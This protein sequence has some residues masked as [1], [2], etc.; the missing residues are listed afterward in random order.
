MSSNQTSDEQTFD[1]EMATS[2]DVRSGYLTGPGIYQMPV[3]YNVVDGIALFSG[4]ID[5]GPVEEVEAEAARIRATHQAR[6]AD[7]AHGEEDAGTEAG[8]DMVLLGVGLPRDSSFLW[9]NG[10]VAYAIASN[11]SNPS[12]ITDAIRHL[13]QRSP[14]RFTERTAAN[15]AQHPN[16]IEFIQHAS[17]NSSPIGMRGGR[18]RIR[19]TAGA[20]LGT[21]VHEIMHSLG[22]FHEQSRS[23]RDSF[24][25]IRWQNIDPTKTGNFQKVPGSVDYYDYDYGSLMHYP[26][27]A[28]SVNGQDTIVPRRSGVS[29]GQRSAMSWGDRQTVAKLYERF[30]TK[31]YSGVW[32]AHSGRYGLWAN[33]SWQSFQ[34]KWQEWSG[35]GLR[36]IDIHT[37]RVG[38]TT[39]YTGVFRAGS[40]SHGLWVNSSFS[41]FTNKWRDWSG[42][43]LRLVSVH[44][45]RVGN[46]NRYTGAWLPGSGSYALWL[47]ASWTSFRG[48]WQEWNGAGMRLVDL[49]VHR[50]NGQ[51]RY[52]GVWLAGSG[53]YGLWVNANWDSFIA[54]WREWGGQ[55]LRLVDLNIHKVN[56]QNRYSGVW[57][58]GGGSYALWAN[59][60]W[61][62]FRAKWE[63]LAERGMQLVDYDFPAAEVGAQGDADALAMAD[64]AAT[65]V[66]AG[67]EIDGFGGIVGEEPMP[68]AMGEPLAAPAETGAGQGGLV[69]GSEAAAMTEAEADGHGD[70]VIMPDA[71]APEAADTG[72]GDGQGG[73]SD[74]A[75]VTAASTG[76]GEG[77]VA[78]SPGVTG[79]QVVT[80]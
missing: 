43:G 5:M 24:V 39:R 75:Q 23:D 51:N 67:L 31:G 35:S 20:P 77:G 42:Q 59:V 30:F 22:I 18:Q 26:R 72:A 17:V 15:A 6:T 16:W 36:L 69:V 13:E 71:T 54:K 70:A 73:S 10:R 44:V 48:K 45:H 60:T 40:G 2:N 78:R 21:V 52:S 7:P 55:G 79:P 76:N 53:R 56:G 32:R 37:R 19:L 68:L 64:A 46:Q 61:H 66:D 12:R 34:P 47:N 1:A 58:E 38:N 80:H 33:A 63:E 28:F 41:S 29:I 50:V 25:D 8:T 62:S 65:Q 11:F 9:P 57:R 49:H 14:I 4:C 3:E 27:R 74:E